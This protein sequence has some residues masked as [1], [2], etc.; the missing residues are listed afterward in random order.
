MVIIDLPIPEYDFED[1]EL[2][3][4]YVVLCQIR[5]YQ[6]DVFDDRVPF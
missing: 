1:P 2:D 6:E 5:E 3:P 4:D